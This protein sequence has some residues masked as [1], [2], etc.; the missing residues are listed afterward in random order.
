MK[1]LLNNMKRFPIY[2]LKLWD[3]ENDIVYNELF[4]IEVGANYEI[5]DA[6]YHSGWKTSPDGL[7]RATIYGKGENA[8]E[9]G[10][11]LLV[12]ENLKTNKSTIYKLKD[13]SVAQNTPKYVEWIDENR[14]FVI[15]GFAHG[16]V[17]KGGQL[18]EMNL[19]DN[20]VMPVFEDLAVNEEITSIKANDDGTFTYE[21]YDVFSEGY[22]EEGILQLPPAKK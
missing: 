19:E 15:V 18:Y 9:E 2:Y 1:S 7:Q 3:R 8:I 4:E 10:E 21:K 5:A 22:L 16:T 14:L 12:I 6:S 17:T 13:N 20:T 11:A